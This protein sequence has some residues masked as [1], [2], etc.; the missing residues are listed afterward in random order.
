MNKIKYALLELE[1]NFVPHSVVYTVSETSY[2]KA[3]KLRRNL[4]LYAT[5]MLNFDYI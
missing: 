1:L 4:F 2:Y 3:Y 5:L